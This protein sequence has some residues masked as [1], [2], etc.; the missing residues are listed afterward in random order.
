MTGADI[1]KTLPAPRACSGSRYPERTGIPDPILDPAGAAAAAAIPEP[2][3]DTSRATQPPGCCVIR[4]DSPLS[5]TYGKRPPK[6]P[7]VTVLAGDISPAERALPLLTRR[8]RGTARAPYF[9][10]TEA[11]IT[12]LL[13]DPAF[14]RHFLPHGNRPRCT[15]GCQKGFR[16]LLLRARN[17]LSS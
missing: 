15:P 17:C 4:S 13:G 2:A 5:F 14:S 7:G 9:E 1:T 8:M 12:I 16:N 10:F 6:E 3:V 11:Q